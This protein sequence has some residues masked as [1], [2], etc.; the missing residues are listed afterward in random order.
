MELY[1]N[2]MSVCAQKVRLVIHEK[3]LEP[4]EHHMVLRNGD[5][6]QPEYLKL[7]P[8]GVVPT[9][10]DKGEVITE[11][12]I[13]CDYLDEAYPRNPLYPEDPLAK[14]RVRLWTMKPDTS[15]HNACGVLSVVIAFRHQMIEAGGKQLEN[16]PDYADSPVSNAELQ[17]AIEK[18]F[19]YERVSNAVRVYDEVIGKMA[20]AL[21]NF[22]W[23]CGDTYTMADVAMLPYVCRFEDLSLS[24]FWDGKRSVVGDWLER[25]KARRNYSG[26]ADYLVSVYLDLTREKGQEATPLIKKILK[27][28]EAS[29][30]H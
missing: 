30:S 29:A 18:G 9:L 14:T 24:W 7:N 6:H 11:S 21:Q 12:T 10:V 2:N 5:V 27:D 25:A 3:Q 26:I 13:I 23:L 19:E 8:K 28:I 4:V 17:E 16:R 15:L 1:H 20:E 22:P